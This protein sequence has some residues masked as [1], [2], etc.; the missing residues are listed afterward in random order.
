MAVQPTRQLLAQRQRID[1]MHAD[2]SGV[3]RSNRQLERRIALLNN[4][5][6][7]EQEARKAGLV[8]PGETLYSVVPPARSAR[9]RHRLNEPAAAAATPGFMERFLHFVGLL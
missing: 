2:L 6:Y 1:D 9:Q 5:D 3:M 8:R 4:P 7:L